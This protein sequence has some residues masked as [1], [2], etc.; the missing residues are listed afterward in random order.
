MHPVRTIAIAVAA[1][2]LAL[3][4]ALLISLVSGHSATAQNLARVSRNV[5]RAEVAAFLLL[6]AAGFIYEQRA[7]AS[8]EMLVPKSGRLVKVGDTH[9]FL[10]CMGQGANTVVLEYGL[11]GARFDWQRVAPELSRFTRVCVYDRAG[12]GWSEPSKR[13]RTPNVM[14]DELHTLLQTSGEKPPYIVVGHSFGGFNALMFAHLFPGEVAGIVLVDSMHPDMHSGSRLTE[15]LWLTAMQMAVPFGLPRWRNLCGVRAEGEFATTTC[16]SRFYRAIVREWDAVPKSA[17]QVREIK[18]VGSIPLLVIT[19][20]PALGEGAAHENL[21]RT[22]LPL[23]SQSQ[24]IVAEGS[25][26][27]IPKA[28]PDVVID[29]VKRLVKPQAPAGNLG[30]L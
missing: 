25:G 19:R 27:D 4:A 23:S 18:N 3:L 12:Y 26:H 9:L 20:D 13:P 1:F 14:A 16:R 10:Q 17:E 7:R 8:E 6:M 28:R 5:I 24:F 21:E 29:A 15:K 2:T 11:E 30:N 22:F